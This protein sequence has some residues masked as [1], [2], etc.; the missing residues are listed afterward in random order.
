M[1]VLGGVDIKIIKR[2]VLNVWFVHHR[3]SWGAKAQQLL[4]GLWL[5]G[6]VAAYPFFWGNWI[7]GF[8]RKVDGN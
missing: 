6:Q 5:L 3:S 4:D 7:A 8:R 1:F 2:K